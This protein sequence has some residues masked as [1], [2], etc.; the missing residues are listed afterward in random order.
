MRVVEPVSRRFGRIDPKGKKR[1]KG[2]QFA[3]TASSPSNDKNGNL[4]ST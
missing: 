1:R 4:F 2:E 3:M